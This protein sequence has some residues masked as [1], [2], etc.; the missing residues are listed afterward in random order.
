[1]NAFRK[2]SRQFALQ[3]HVAVRQTRASSG[4]RILNEEE[5]AAE[6]V[7]I[8][9]QEAEKAE[10]LKKLRE[11]KTGEAAE[12]AAKAA[13]QAAESVKIRAVNEGQKVAE[14]GSSSLYSL[15]GAALAGVGLG[16]FLFGGK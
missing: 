12:A 7:F 1:M 16:W 10:F 2:S 4:G 5:K 8:K 9:K 3:S 6:N 11:G 14:G 13:G 15:G